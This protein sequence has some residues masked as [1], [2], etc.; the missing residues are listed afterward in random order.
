MD[1]DKLRTDPVRDGNVRTMIKVLARAEPT[2][3]ELLSLLNLLMVEPQR[4]EIH[5]FL[6]KWCRR[7]R[8]KEGLHNGN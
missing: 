7:L 4:R 6:S 5:A 1:Q 3:T 8:E 2:H